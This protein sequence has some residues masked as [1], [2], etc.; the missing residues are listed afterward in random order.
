MAASRRKY[1]SAEVTERSNALDLEPG[2][3]AWR[4]PRRIAES[5]KRSADTSLRRKGTPLQSAMSM[6]NF[7]MNRAGAN[8]SQRQRTTLERAKKELR[9]LYGR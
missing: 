7:Y 6:L 5:L 1:W 3:F 8:L 9:G 2:V 4:D